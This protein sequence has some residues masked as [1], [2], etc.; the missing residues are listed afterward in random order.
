MREM[1]SIP[2]KVYIVEMSS[3]AGEFL[4][5]IIHQSETDL[6]VLGKVAIK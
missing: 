1:K 5:F 6:V 3:E 4:L 2:G